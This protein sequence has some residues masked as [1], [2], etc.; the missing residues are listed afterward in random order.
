MIT[1]N[2]FLPTQ[3]CS[4]RSPSLSGK[5]HYTTNIA[6]ANLTSPLWIIRLFIIQ[7]F[8]NQRSWMYYILLEYWS[9]SK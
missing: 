1:I 8:S 5:Q 4:P 7:S 2:I 9:W 6:P 3:L